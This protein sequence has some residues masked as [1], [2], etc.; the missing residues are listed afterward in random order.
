MSF[1]SYSFLKSYGGD[2]SEFI[3]LNKICSFEKVEN[4]LNQKKLFEILSKIELEKENIHLN[5]QQTHIKVE[6]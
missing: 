1:F 6:Y 3:S 2:Q 4:L 5:S